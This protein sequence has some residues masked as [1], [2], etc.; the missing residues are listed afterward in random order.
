MLKTNFSEL[1][2]MAHW[3]PKKSQKDVLNIAGF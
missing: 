1:T 3:M 2:F